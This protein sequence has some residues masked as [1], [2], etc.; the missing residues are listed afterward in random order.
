[1]SHAEHRT[2]YLLFRVLVA[3]VVIAV[4]LLV[5]TPIASRASVVR[6]ALTPLSLTQVPASSTVYVL[7]TS[8]C[9][10]PSCLRLLRTSVDA[11]T[12]TG[13]SLPPMRSLRGDLTGSIDSISFANVDDGYA[14]VG[15]T[16][17][18]TLFVTLNGARSWRRV[19]VQKGARTLGLTTTANGIYAL[20]GVCSTSGSSCGD[21]RIAH[22]SFGATKW[23]S[24]KMPLGHFGKHGVWGFPYVP[25]ASGNQVWISEQPP[26]SAI[27]FYSR[28]GG[29]TFRKLVTPQLAS[30]NACGL[31]P[32]STTAL[33]AACP[34]G[35][36]E[37]FFFSKNAGTSWTSVPQRPFFGT[38]GG[39]FDP[40][41]ASLAF[42]DYGA[43]RPLIRL[44]TTPRTATRVG[45]L[46]CSKVNSSVNGLIFTNVHDGLALCEPD[47][48]QSVGRLETT[49]DGGRTWRQVSMPRDR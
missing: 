13:A 23:T 40:V 8:G 30:V 3:A 14:I 48:G 33:W 25:A 37:S 19:I 4:A 45:V 38:G 36:Q 27:I 6:K 22:S 26:G 1:M 21:Y 34:T 47:D 2:R 18:T 7:A 44:T 28:D 9:A 35:M 43:S 32:E 16:G 5:A 20:T 39:F 46:S 31:I 11:A 24:T 10:R 17:P 15:V 49:T 41:S 29:K 42:L 12:F